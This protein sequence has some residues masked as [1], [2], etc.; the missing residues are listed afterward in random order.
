MA[1]FEMEAGRLDMTVMLLVG[2]TCLLRTGEL[3]QLKTT[4]F[5]MGESS[6]VCSLKNTKSGRR[7]NAN[8]VVSFDDIPTVEAV[9]QLL[10]LR[11]QTNTG[12][13]LWVHSAGYFRQ[14]FKFL[15]DHFDLSHH[16]FRPYS[17]R[18]GGATHVFQQSGSMEV[19]LLKGRWQSGRVARIYICDGLSYLPSLIMS[20]RTKQL[21]N[22][23]HFFS[24]HQG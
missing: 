5:R 17:L 9:K 14:Q 19:A 11:R 3:L 22:Q 23:F 21:L 4:D 2:F 8:E 18:R 15:C 13:W 1:S 10:L 6:G 16:Q 12:P 20:K 7:D 24:S